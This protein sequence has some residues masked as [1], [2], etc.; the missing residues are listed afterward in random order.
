MF[1]TSKQVSFSANPYL[2]KI[3][4]FQII[5][6]NHLSLTSLFIYE[7]TK[8]NIAQGHALTSNAGLIFMTQPTT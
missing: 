4:D 8:K 5:T 7:L 2:I 6:F 1:T 3:Y